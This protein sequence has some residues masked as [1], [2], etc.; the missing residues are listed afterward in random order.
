MPSVVWSST[1]YKLRLKA[2]L[3]WKKYSDGDLELP[4]PELGNCKEWRFEV[5]PNQLSAV[6]LG[7]WERRMV[8]TGVD[9]DVISARIEPYLQ[10]N[11]PIV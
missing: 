10:S 2:S 11:S 5:D 6:F 3:D 4:P 7:V 9:L 1:R 8:P